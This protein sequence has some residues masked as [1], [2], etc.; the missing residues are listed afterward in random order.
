MG[1]R[2]WIPDMTDKRMDE[3][4]QAVTADSARV[5]VAMQL[6]DE[7]IDPP[8]RRPAFCTGTGKMAVDGKCP[9]CGAVGE[10]SPPEWFAPMVE[11]S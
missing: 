3:V 1:P 2:E 10:L 9:D 8:R 4:A 7:V 6:P 5:R 11:H